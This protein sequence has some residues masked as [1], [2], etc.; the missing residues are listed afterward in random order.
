MKRSSLFWKIDS[1]NCE[2]LENFFRTLFVRVRLGFQ[3]GGRNM[4]KKRNFLRTEDLT[5]IKEPQQDQAKL[6][7]A[8]LFLNCFKKIEFLLYQIKKE[9]KGDLGILSCELR[10]FAKCRWNWIAC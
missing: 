10:L 2:Y 3:R 4:G 7:N 1:E 5:A 8:H 9:V 6:K